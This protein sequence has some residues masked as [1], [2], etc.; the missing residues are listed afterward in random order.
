MRILV[1]ILYGI[2]WSI[3]F[4]FASALAGALVTAGLEALFAVFDFIGPSFAYIF[5]RVVAIAIMVLGP[6]TGFYIGYTRALKKEAQNIDNK[7]L[8]KKL[9]FPVIVLCITGFIVYILV[10]NMRAY[11]KYGFFV[12]ASDESVFVSKIDP[13]DPRIVNHGRIKKEKIFELDRE[14]DKG[15][16]RRQGKVRWYECYGIDCDEGWETSLIE[17]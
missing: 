5:T 17:R 13:H 16:G 9:V 12:H 8:V 3:C 14:I 1:K 4:I 15:D 10:I 2:V 7:R 6:I 11:N